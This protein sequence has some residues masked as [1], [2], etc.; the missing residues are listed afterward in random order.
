MEYKLTQNLIDE[1]NYLN[2]KYKLTTIKEI[3]QSYPS[4]EKFQLELKK[5]INKTVKEENIYLKL[6]INETIS[7]E[8]FK[9][10]YAELEFEIIEY[11]PFLTNKQIKLYE[12]IIIWNNVSKYIPFQ[13]IP[14]LKKYL[15][16]KIT[17]ERFAKNK[18]FP[19]HTLKSQLFNIINKD[20][21]SKN[22]L[23]TN[24]ILN[25]IETILETKSQKIKKQRIKNILEN[26]LYL[27]EAQNCSFTSSS[28]QESQ[29]IMGEDIL[30][31][32]SF[33]KEKQIKNTKYYNIMLNLNLK[34][35]ENCT[36]IKALQNYINPIFL[37][38]L[39]EKHIN[40][41][42]KTL[43]SKS[44]DNEN[45]PPEIKITLDNISSIYPF[46]IPQIINA[47]NKNDIFF[48][49]ANF[50]IYNPIFI[51]LIKK[52]DALELYQKK[53]ISKKQLITLLE[54]IKIPKED[55]QNI[56]KSIS[57]NNLYNKNMKNLYDFS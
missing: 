50:L 31:F 6:L 32:F 53:I 37:Q 33:F 47:Y 54:N 34:L 17:T 36:L 14:K 51:Q 20:E 41:I 16:D 11:L 3:T 45:I 46:A 1:L 18:I 10:L 42:I 48:L 15:N 29:L 40:S 8:T 4:I 2:D 7:K 19:K 56:T 38:K 13:Y 24:F 57:Q 30:N 22:K 43:K 35:Q 55:I 52:E 23:E 26:N 5:I 28:S 25:H 21:L 39:M 9:I 27:T 44:F 12:D 49:N